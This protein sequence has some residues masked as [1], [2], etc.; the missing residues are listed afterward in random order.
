MA[1]DDTKTCPTCDG[2]G[3]I[4]AGNR[5][6]PDCSGTGKVSSDFEATG[7]NMRKPRHRSIGGNPMEQEWRQW[8]TEG[9]QVRDGGPTANTIELTGMPIVYN[10]PYQVRDS[11]GEFQE[12]M[13]PGVASSLLDTADCRFLINHTGMPLARTAHNDVAGTMTLF[14]SAEGVRFNASLSARSQAANDLADAIARGDVDQMSVGFCVGKDAWSGRDAYG[15]ENVR[16]IASLSE[17]LDVS[18]VTYP[19]SPTTSIQIAQRSLEP[20]NFSLRIPDSRVRARKVFFS[21]TDEQRLQI[22]AGKVLSAANGAALQT[23]LQAMVDAHAAHGQALDALSALAAAAG[24]PVPDKPSGNFAPT[25]GNAGTTDGTQNAGFGAGPIGNTQAG[26]NTGSRTRWTGP[27]LVRAEPAPATGAPA[28]SRFGPTGSP[29]P[30]PATGAPAGSR[31]TGSDPASKSA[32]AQNTKAA[33]A[34]AAGNHT[35]AAAAHVAAAQHFTQAAAA[36]SEVPQQQNADHAAA[37]AHL[38]AAGAHTAA[39]AAPAGAGRASAAANAQAATKA[40]GAAHTAAKSGWAAYD[41]AK[42]KGK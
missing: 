13:L 41:A 1:D 35:T 24:V 14:D 2:D 23:G 42:S 26:D 9:F 21:L 38:A 22:R 19:A 11:V 6:C 30:A 8:T 5:K 4:L 34:S 15:L 20:V 33:T 37:G 29:A 16:E 25:P 10:V 27:S 18:A 17:L 31:Y 12:T 3:T 7:D 39:A 36:H 40:A 28:G 32:A